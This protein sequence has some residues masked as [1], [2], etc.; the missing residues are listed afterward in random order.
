M[1]E[2]VAYLSIHTSPLARPGSGDAGGM[3]V[4]MH[5]LA[6]TM[7]GRGV[8]VDVY[9]RRPG[10]EAPD[11]VEVAPGYRVFNIDAGPTGP[12]PTTDPGEVVGEFAE[13]VL[14]RALRNRVRY[15]V[16]HSHYWLSGWAGLLL[17]EVLG[18]PLAIS[19]HTLGRV[20]DANRRADEAPAGL[21]RIA[22][23]T[24]L[25]SRAGCVIASTPAEAG[26]LI[27]H[28]R[29]D[30]GRLCVS[31]P[32]ID[33]GVFH[34]GSRE[35]ARAWLDLGDGPLVLFV[36]RIQPH[37]GADLAVAAFAGVA[38]DL[39][40]ARLLV[41]GGPS[42]PDGEAEVELLRKAA[43]DL[44]MTGRM[45]IRDPLSHD[46]MADVYRAAD[47][48]VVP[49]RSESFGLVAVEAQA[50]GV[51]VVAARVGGLAYA[52][53][54]GESGFLVE[55]WDPG[56]Y[57]DAI[58]AILTDPGLRARLA[59][60]A[61]DNAGGFSWAATADRLLELYVGISSS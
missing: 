2:R 12:M 9:T 61:V 17:H 33:H 27:E 16:L 45:E 60:G 15:D 31:P 14:S 43:A 54:D 57:A 25:I 52:V 19:F 47:V 23:E 51:P 40:D 4:Y 1:I 37:K 56:A 29:A 53:T 26:E 46:R 50:C 6:Q 34:P 5:E 58:R 10:P 49:S 28:Y 32:G 30:P 11:E 13:G 3:N 39:P 8:A 20:K 41:I 22:A 59:A 24:D 44:G 18:V 55:E 35:E 48:L 7:A 38:A 42:G 21:F 36:G